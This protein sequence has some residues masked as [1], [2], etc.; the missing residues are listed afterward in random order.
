MRK[1][2]TKIRE[3]SEDG[4]VFSLEWM[5]KRMKRERERGGKGD[6][7][8]QRDEREKLALQ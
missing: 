4:D 6:E 5:K 7:R 3:Q 2:R 8:E 1:A